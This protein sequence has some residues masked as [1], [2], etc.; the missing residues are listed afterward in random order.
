MTVASFS[1]I[2]LAADVLLN[3]FAF[4]DGWTIVWPLNGIT[5]A[6]LLMRPRSAWPLMLV[7]VEILGWQRLA[8]GNRP[9]VLL[10]Y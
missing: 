3:T 10:G 1:L 5:V 2:Y 6:L 8:L 7:G 9:A 4:S